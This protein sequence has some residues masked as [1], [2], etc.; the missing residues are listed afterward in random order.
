VPPVGTDEEDERDTPAA[1]P[2]DVPPRSAVSSADAPGPHGAPGLPGRVR[3]TGVA[4]YSWSSDGPENTRHALQGLWTISAP[5]L[6]TD[7]H[8]QRFGP[9]VA[10]GGPMTLSGSWSCPANLQ[11]RVTVLLDP[12]LATRVWFCDW[13]AGPEVLVRR[14]GPPCTN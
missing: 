9:Y 8:A 13:L 12:A 7:A 2:G 6:Y 4:C 1:D 11:L 10:A 14:A 5:G 3:R